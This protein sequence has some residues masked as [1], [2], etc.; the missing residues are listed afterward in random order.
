MRRLANSLIFRIFLRIFA[1]DIRLALR[2]FIRLIFN[3]FLVNYDFIFFI[4]ITSTLLNLYFL[5]ISIRQW[6]LLFLYASKRR[7]QE[8][9]IF[10]FGYET[11]FI[12]RVSNPFLMFATHHH[13]VQISI[14]ISIVQIIINI[15]LVHF[16]ITGKVNALF[17]FLVKD[18][19]KDFLVT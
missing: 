9:F 4:L 1:Y 19:E 3:I 2:I 5:K 8:L 10:V 12:A 13:I 18:H 6:N 7:G 14:E 16:S 11:L 15:H 17:L